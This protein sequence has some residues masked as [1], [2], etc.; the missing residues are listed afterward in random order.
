MVPPTW[1]FGSFMWLEGGWE[2]IRVHMTQQRKSGIRVPSV[3][4]D[5]TERIW[6]LQAGR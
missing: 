3:A 4:P 1:R 2:K 6:S 5:T